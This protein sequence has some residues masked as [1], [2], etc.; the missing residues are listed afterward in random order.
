[1]RYGRGMTF[2]ERF[3]TKAAPDVAFRYLAD[4]TNLPAWDPGITSVEKLTPGPVGVGSRY[5][6]AMRFLGFPTTLD[7]HVET[8]EPGK[9]AVL[10]GRAPGTLATDTVTVSANRNGARVRWQAEISLAFPMS[11]ADPLLSWLFSSSV[12]AAV[13]NLKRELDALAGPAVPPT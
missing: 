12:T 11:L 10:V 8:H 4:F 9:R 6:V 3:N 2:D 7:Y 13:A 5:R 1:M